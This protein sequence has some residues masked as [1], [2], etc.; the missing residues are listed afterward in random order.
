MTI[1]LESV[2][3][4]LESVECGHSPD[5]DHVACNR[6]K[7]FVLVYENGPHPRDTG[8]LMVVATELGHEPSYGIGPGHGTHPG[9]D[10]AGE[11]V[12]H[13]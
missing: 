9:T 2:V 8:V 13:A 10:S 12:P 3:D 11:R 1:G 4:S 5:G 6:V 7:G